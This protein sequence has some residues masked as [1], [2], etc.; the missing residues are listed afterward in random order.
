MP[1]DD[2]HRNQL[3]LLLP[4]RDRGPSV[5]AESLLEDLN[6]PQREAVLHSRGPLLVLAG[7]GSGKT[8]ALTRKI[9]FLVQVERLAPWEIL[10]VTFTNKAAGEMR[11]R[12]HALLGDRAADLWLGTFHAIGVRLLRQHGSRLGVGRNFV[13]YDDDD[14]ET[15]LKRVLKAL[16][17]SDKSYPIKALRAFIDEQKQL[18]RE[19]DHPDIPRGTSHARTMAQVYVSYAQQMRSANAVDFNDLILLPWLLATRFEDVGFEWRARWRYVLVDEFQDTNAAQY[20]LLKALVGPQRNLCVVGDDDQSIYGWRGAEVENILG[21]PNEYKDARVIR[22]EQNYRSTPQILQLSTALIAQNRDRHGKVLWTQKTDGEPI[23][24]YAAQTEQDEAEW[25]ARRIREL[26]GRYPLA[27]MAIFY[28]TNAQSRAFEEALRTCR[29]PYRVYG[30]LRFYDRAEIKDILAYLRLIHNPRDGVS[31]ERIINSP[32]R[33]IGKTTLERL[34]TRASSRDETLWEA[35]VAEA[36]A[37]SAG[38]GKLGAFVALISELQTLAKTATALAVVDAVLSKTSYINVL[39]ADGTVESETRA[40]NVRELVSAIAA[41]TQR[42]EEPGLGGFLDEVAL[43]SALDTDGESADMV[44]LMTAHMAKGLEFDVAFVTGLEEELIPHVNSSESA[45]GLEEERRLAYVALTRARLHLHLSHAGTRRRFGQV[46]LMSPS[47][48]LDGLP[49]DLLRLE[50]LAGRGSNLGG[51]GSGGLGRLVGAARTEASG[52][53]FAR[54][55]AQPAAHR[56]GRQAHDEAGTD[57]SA[58]S[59][60]EAPARATRQVVHDP[61]DVR[62]P[63]PSWEDESQDREDGVLARGRRIFHPTFGEGRV[64][65]VEGDGPNAKVTVRF[66]DSVRKI[67]ARALVLR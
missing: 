6:A 5:S 43:V 21:F 42:A 7:A 58:D 17:L 2:R 64:E 55:Y 16:N 19:P 60:W 24:L 44:V 1:P 15:L 33:G 22:F 50:G 35:V 13:I 57:A 46:K 37:S 31:L 12:C 30:G 29:I 65:L 18:G 3:E 9:A 23:R 20:L 62:D 32:A 49:R 61:T 28:R 41:Y 52:N 54:S 51:G 36:A 39:E 34:E 14:Q 53:P 45:R 56:A 67:V 25:V 59:P 27:E 48:F 66:R 11:E 4:S 10:A 38:Q 26:R 8:R 63:T 40:E 47:R